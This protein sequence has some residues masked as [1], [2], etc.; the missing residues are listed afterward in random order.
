MVVDDLDLYGALGGPNETDPPLVADANAV[1]ALSIAAQSF[2][3]VSRERGQVLKRG[4]RFDPVE[5]SDRCQAD[6]VESRYTPALV[7]LTVLVVM[8]YVK[9]LGSLT[10]TG[11]DR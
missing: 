9:R 10:G 1:L 2:K 8:R 5:P 4:C 11:T 6:C 3:S 7:S